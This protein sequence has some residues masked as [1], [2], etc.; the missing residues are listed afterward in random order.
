MILA[1]FD[2]G[3]VVSALGWAGNPRFCLDLVYAGQAKLCVTPD[4]WEEYR[5]KVP[6]ILAEQQRAVDAELEIGLLLKVVHFVTP[7]LLGKRRSRDPQDD[8]YLAAALGVGAA[9]VVSNDRDL[10]A[11]GKP[12]G[13]PV[14][15][16]V[17]FLRLARSR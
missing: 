16:P 14:V 6:L 4:I 15:T 9:A 7:A 5:V 2:C 11:L 12:F 1:V 8:R 13:V 10:L 3:V 17:Q